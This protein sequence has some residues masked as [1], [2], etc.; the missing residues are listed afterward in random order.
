M[1]FWN[2]AS[3]KEKESRVS[4][5]EESPP[6]EEL[7]GQQVGQ[8]ERCRR[9]V[10]ARDTTGRERNRERQC[11]RYHRPKEHEDSTSTRAAVKGS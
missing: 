11:V 7:G 10:T 8:E 5:H 9:S 2:I 6:A 4:R 3:S 1:V